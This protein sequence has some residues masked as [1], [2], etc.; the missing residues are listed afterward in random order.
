MSRRGSV[1][2][3]WTWD[4][5][6]GRSPR[7]RNPQRKG[8]DNF[9]TGDGLSLLVTFLQFRLSEREGKDS[10]TLR[11]TE[12]NGSVARLIGHGECAGVG[13]TGYIDSHRFAVQEVADFSFSGENQLN[14]LGVELQFDLRPGFRADSSRHIAHLA[15]HFALAQRDTGGQLV[16]TAVRTHAGFLAVPA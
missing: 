6:N 7:R 1:P 15:Q 9:L 5:W 10:E 16:G 8:P 2:L 3:P 11:Q 12:F 14:F 13:N 4:T